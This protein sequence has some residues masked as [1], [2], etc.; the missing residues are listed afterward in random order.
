M[1]WSAENR[2]RRLRAKFP[3]ARNPVV[4]TKIEKLEAILEVDN[5]ASNA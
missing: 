4:A 2:L 1:W 3:K 5:D